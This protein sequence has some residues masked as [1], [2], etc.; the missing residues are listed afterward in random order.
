MKRLFFF[1]FLPFVIETNFILQVSSCK[2][3]SNIGFLL[4][5]HQ[6]ITNLFVKHPILE[7]PDGFLNVKH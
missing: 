1:Y 3:M 2:E 7:L 4:L 5:T 6:R